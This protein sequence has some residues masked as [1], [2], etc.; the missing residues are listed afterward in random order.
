MIINNPFAFPCVDQRDANGIGIA[1]GAPGMT[2]RDYFAGQALAGFRVG[3][4]YTSWDDLAADCY[5]AADAMLAARNRVP[6]AQPAMQHVAYY[7]EGEFHWMS[8]VAPRDC[9]LFA[10]VKI[11]GDA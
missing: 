8:G 4:V 9:E 6:A 3:R 11:G 10:P 7:D 2:L 1:E 5:D